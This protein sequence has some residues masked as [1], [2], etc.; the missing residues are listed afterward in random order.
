VWS[1]R[2]VKVSS[3]SIRAVAISYLDSPQRQH[4]TPALEPMRTSPSRFENT[5]LPG[6]C[7]TCALLQCQKT[8]YVYKI[9]EVK[10][11]N[12]RVSGLTTVSSNSCP[13][14]P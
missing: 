3:Y 10:R 4:R 13:E 14:R 12:H 6:I 9:E 8:R 1:E 2:G 5:S 11:E 7:H